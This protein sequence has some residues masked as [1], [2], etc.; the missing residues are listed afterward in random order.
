ME[1]ASD[2]WKKFESL[3]RDIR[4]IERDSIFI[5][6]YT[7]TLFDFA[8]IAVFTDNIKRNPIRLMKIGI[9]GVLN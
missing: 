2:M 3:D 5:R 6:P 7:Q 1:L 9:T 4:F 8:D